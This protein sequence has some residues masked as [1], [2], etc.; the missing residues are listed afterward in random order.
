MIVSKQSGQVAG[1]S[2]RLLASSFVWAPSKALPVF[3]LPFVSSFDKSPIMA[4]E[5]RHPVLADLSISLLSISIKSCVESSLIV[6]F[7]K[8]PVNASA[9][10]ISLSRTSVRSTKVKRRRRIDSNSAIEAALSMRYSENLSR[11]GISFAGL[12]W[13]RLLVERESARCAAETGFWAAQASMPMLR[14]VPLPRSAGVACSGCCTAAHS[15]L[16]L[17]G[18]GAVV[19]WSFPPRISAI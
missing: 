5:S 12:I 4:T 13:I 19:G 16:Q 9:N 7:P 15:A 14:P 6:S 2:R 18:M 3:R 1:R 10:L 11:A 17:G 8:I